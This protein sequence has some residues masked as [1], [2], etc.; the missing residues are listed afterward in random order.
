MVFHHSIWSGFVS[1]EGG[2]KTSPKG[3]CRLMENGE[4][5]V[6][7]F[8]FPGGKARGF[9]RREVGKFLI[10]LGVRTYLNS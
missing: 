3:T 1:R 8:F 7:F 2:I 5:E 9:G 6:F 4:K 10:F